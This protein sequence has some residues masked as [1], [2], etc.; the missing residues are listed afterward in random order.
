MTILSHGISDM[1]FKADHLFSTDKHPKLRE[2]KT[3]SFHYQHF[4]KKKFITNI[5]EY[6]V[7]VTRCVKLTNEK[8]FQISFLFP[9]K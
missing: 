9:I 3:I 5:L 4:V 2:K 1:G 7:K 6:K 8:I